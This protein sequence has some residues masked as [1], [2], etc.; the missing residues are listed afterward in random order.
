MKLALTMENGNKTERRLCCS[1]SFKLMLAAFCFSFAINA[2]SQHILSG[3]VT[4]RMNGKPLPF[5]SISFGNTGKGTVANENGEF[6]CALD[7]SE[8][9]FLAFGFIG[10]ETKQIFL[11]APSPMMVSLEPLPIDL[12]EVEV[13]SGKKSWVTECINLAVKKIKKKRAVFSTKGFFSLETAIEGGNPLEVVEAFYQCSVSPRKG[14]ISTELKNGRFGLSPASGLYFMDVNPTDVVRNLSIFEKSDYRLPVSPFSLGANEMKNNF[15]FFIDSVMQDGKR[16]VAVIRFV[17]RT[18]TGRSFSGTVY[19]DTVSHDFLKISLSCIQAAVHPFHP[20]DTTHRITDVGLNFTIVFRELDKGRQAPDYLRFDYRLN[21]RGASS[22]FT[23]KS[24]S[25]LL[26]YDYDNFFILPYYISSPY[27]NDYGKILS[28]PFNPV[29]WERN[30]VIPTTQALLDHSRYFMQNGLTVNYSENS[31]CKGVYPQ[32][33][34][35][36]EPGIELDWKMIGIKNPG[37]IV[38][39]GPNRRRPDA[40][41]TLSRKYF[42]DF[43]VLLDFNQERDSCYWQSRS[44][45]FLP[46][47]FYEPERD[48]NALRVFNL[49]FD[50]T[51]LYRLRLEHRLDSVTAYGCDPGKVLNTYDKLVKQFEGMRALYK[52][53]VKRGQDDLS[54]QTWKKRISLR[55][56][57]ENKK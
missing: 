37:Y 15:R 12:K 50:M 6:R 11:P 24:K 33:A 35:Y 13:L 42:M 29:F 40:E 10:Y 7:T 34:V 20:I 3:K 16:S 22:A 41:E 21:Y 45:L 2:A 51:E 28:V 17:P 57:R 53:E 26:L 27:L 30:Y 39:G 54:F 43:Q 44:M 8:I 14:I 19:V 4:D 5:V 48:T 38:V 46:P 1:H 47:S 25:L 31:D 23:M 52:R 56:E 9:S 55:L 32:Q 36:W 18:R 49:E